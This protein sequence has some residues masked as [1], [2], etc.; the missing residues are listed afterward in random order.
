[1][2]RIGICE[3]VLEE[4][5][6]QGKMVRTIMGD[7]SKNVDLYCFQSGEDLLFEIDTTGNMDI[8]FLDIE[9]RGMNGVETAR[10][11]RNRDTRVVLIFV[12]CHDQYCKEIIEVQPFAFI[13]KPMKKKRLEKVLK[14]VLETRFFLSE[15]YSFTYHKRQY[16]IPLTH[17][18]YF[19]SDKRIIRLDT[20]Y[21]D[22]YVEEYMFYG[23]LEEVEKAV[24][25][26]NAKFLRIRKSFLVNQ[27]FIIRYSAN[28]VV[29]DNGMEVEISKNYKDA[30]KQRYA[31]FLRDKTKNE[32][33]G[34][35]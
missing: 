19:Q 8:I 15:D 1:M 27:Q 9:M 7:L 3:D 2:I 10:A 4:L 13:D 12:S 31:A 23:K 16:K 14:Y 6:R 20:L 34:S 24:N 5:Q 33:W 17:I 29:L 32:K 22:R 26:T 25:E 30:V 35:T 28:Q 21:K 18:R 11:V